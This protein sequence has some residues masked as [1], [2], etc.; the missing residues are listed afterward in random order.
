MYYDNTAECFLEGTIKSIHF[1]G[2]ESRRFFIKTNDINNSE[3]KLC[4]YEYKLSLKH[5]NWYGNT[6]CFP[7]SKKYM[8][9][10]ILMKFKQKVKEDKHK[11]QIK[12]YITCMS[13]KVNFNNFYNFIINSSMSDNNKNQKIKKYKIALD[14]LNSIRRNGYY[15]FTYKSTDNTVDT[16]KIIF[17]EE[18]ILIYSNKIGNIYITDYYGQSINILNEKITLSK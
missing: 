10:F 17:T 15:Y 13:E 18:N 8:N 14:K 2:Y 7:E 16:K 1:T 6:W 12:E 4:V 11:Q 9:N 5:Y 3:K